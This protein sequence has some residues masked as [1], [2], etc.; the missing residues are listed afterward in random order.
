[1]GRSFRALGVSVIMV[2]I[3]ALLVPLGGVAQ[4]NHPA[5]SC[6]DLS[7]ETDSNPLNTSHV[8]TAT[9]RTPSGQTCG[10]AQTAVDPTNGAVTVQFEITG[11]NDPDSGN[12][13]TSPDRTCTI[14]P[15]ATSCTVS[16]SGATP[17]TDAIRAWVEE[18]ETANVTDADE[19]E[20]VVEGVTPGRLAESDAT[21]VASKTW[22]NPA[23]ATRLDCAPETATNP[24]DTSHTVGC[25]VRDTNDALVSGAIVDVEATGVNDPDGTDS[26]T[27]PDFTCTTGAGGTCQF[28]HDTGTDGAGLTTYRAWVDAD[29]SNTTSEADQT[30]G[31][32]STATPGSVAESDNTD[33]VTKTWTAGAAAALDCDDESGPDSEHETNPGTGPGDPASAETYTCR[34]VDAN[35]NPTGSF[36]VRGEVE[37]A[38]NDPDNPDSNSH[39]TPD[40]QCV[41]TNGTCQIVVTQAESEIGTAD[42]CFW[43]GA[44]AD[45]A[46]LCSNE[47]VGEQAA[48]NGSDG[49]NDFADKVQKTWVTVTTATRLDCTPETDSNPVGTSH[50]IT[51]TART[52]ADALVSGAQIDVEA[53]GVNDPDGTTSNGTPDF[54]C[55]TTASGTCTITDSTGNTVPGTTTYRAWIDRDGS[56]GTIEADSTEGRDEAA[57]P[58]AKAEP[59]DTDVVTKSWT[60][61]ATTLAISPTTDSAPIG[62][63]NPF[64][65]TITDA[66]SQGVSDLTVDVEQ[67]HALATDAVANN[68]PQVAFCTPTSGTN[69]SGMSNNTGDRKES[70]DNAGT[71]GAETTL[72]TDASGRITFGIT[73]TA[74]NGATG[75]GNVAVTAF[76]ET[77]D[78]DD[79]SGTL[80]ATATKTWVTPSPRTISCAPTGG[81]SATGQNHNVTCTVRDQAGQVMSG[82]NVVFTTSGPGTLT[83]ATTVATNQSGQ[84][85]VTATSLDPGVQTITGTLQTDLTGAEPGE[86]DECD[87]AANDPTGSTAGVCAS[88]VTHTW[89]QAPVATAVLTPNEMTTR[90]GGQ[91]TYRF[92]VR[93]ASGVPI[94]GV[95][96]TWT[97]SGVGSFV[98]Q[99]NETNANGTV[100]AVVTSSQPGNSTIVASA[101]GCSSTCSDSSLQ[102]WGPFRCD[103]FGTSGPDVLR[104]TRGSETICAFG[105]R[106]NVVG[107]GG[108]D[109]VLA[110]KGDDSVEGNGDTDVLKGGAG[111]DDLSGGAEQ[112]FL[113]G[114]TGNDVLD[115]G[116]GTDGCRSGPGRDREISC[117][118]RIV[119]GRQQ[120]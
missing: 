102:H 54:T 6:L 62:S 46:T 40:Y 108:Q 82:Q 116:G 87:R 25:T 96:V 42:V 38:V 103:I 39:A 36:T 66:A 113:Y 98:S 43:V 81:S 17:G 20:G 23:T 60:G 94:A 55:T 64:T 73:V 11:V 69:P 112:D 21:D 19:Q 58:G 90:V 33:V 75:A 117:E 28:V 29:G 105:G 5:G 13:L 26:P 7:P 10:S 14:Q 114:G 34:V 71:D 24:A 35:G 119:S 76:F 120:L 53:S 56:N 61:P 51:C 95:P 1:M 107:R 12:S 22:E 27:S 3:T 115:G 80:Q 77:V 84:A 52:S 70:P 109:T 57:T 97:M 68:E 92:Q 31:Q 78:D 88:S 72:R 89:T 110:G 50:T 85:T 30:E 91:E 9:L 45:G 32:D 4:A 67:I 16:Y 37:T 8:L 79:P 86:V 83:T 65:V 93:D 74:A 101:P 63:C 99:E 47:Q 41:T 111:D 15:N 18:N 104:G 2:L 49:G 100:V 59:D 118:G 48:Q 44:P 106:D